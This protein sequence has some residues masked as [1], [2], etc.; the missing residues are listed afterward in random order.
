MAMFL[1]P[2]HFYKSFAPSLSKNKFFL[3]NTPNEDNQQFEVQPKVS[4]E[5]IHKK[6]NKKGVLS[7]VPKA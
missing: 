6:K 5:E 1:H 2:K 4:I 7:E 3:S